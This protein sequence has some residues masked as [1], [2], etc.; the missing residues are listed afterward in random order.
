LDH[1]SALGYDDVAELLRSDYMHLPYTN[2]HMSKSPTYSTQAALFDKVPFVL[3]CKPL[4][5]RGEFILPTS[6]IGF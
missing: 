6:M 5:D 2:I 4:T 1:I 3:N